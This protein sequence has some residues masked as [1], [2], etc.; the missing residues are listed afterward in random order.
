MGLT[1]KEENE[2]IKKIKYGSVV[3]D[4]YV[5]EEEEG[6]KNV[7]VEVCDCCVQKL[8]EEFGEA[9]IEARIDDSGSGEAWCAVEGCENRNAGIYLDFKPSELE[10]IVEA[11]KEYQN[12]YTNESLEDIEK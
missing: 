3:F 1:D 5:E 9:D 6:E 8:K 10:Y 12:G 2:G 7:W 11:E 4:D